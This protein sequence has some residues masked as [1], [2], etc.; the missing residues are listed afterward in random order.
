[1]R[2]MTN[3]AWFLPCADS[4]DPALTEAQNRMVTKAGSGE[5]VKSGQ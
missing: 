1:M 2:K 5:G 3:N 4:E